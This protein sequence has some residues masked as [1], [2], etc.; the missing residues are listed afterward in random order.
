MFRVAS[1]SR[2]INFDQKCFN[3]FANE[4]RRLSIVRYLLGWTLACPCDLRLADMDG[5]W[6]FDWSQYYNTNLE[7][8][9]F[10]EKTPWLISTQVRTMIITTCTHLVELALVLFVLFMASGDQLSPSRTIFRIFLWKNSR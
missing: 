5:R 10:Y 6:R 3:W 4:M 9:C 1:G 8:M 7:R 2:G